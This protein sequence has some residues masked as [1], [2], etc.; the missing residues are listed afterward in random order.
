LNGFYQQSFLIN[1]SVI[2]PLYNCAKT[3][4]RCLH[5]LLILEY[6]KLEVILVD[7]GSTDNTIKIAE[8]F[9]RNYTGKKKI[10]ILR[11]THKGPAAA[12]NL[13][14]KYS[15]GEI[16]FF[17]DSDCEVPRN[18]IKDL[19]KHFK[20]RNIG[21]VGGGVNPSSLSTIYEAFEQ[22]RREILY[23]HKKKFLND[24]PTC[25]LAVRK[26]ILLEIGGFDENFKYASS[27][28]YELCHRIRK[29][30]YKIL[31]DPSIYVIHHHPHTLKQILRRAVTHGKEII[32]L[33]KK[34]GVSLYKEFLCLLGFPRSLIKTFRKYPL[35]LLPIS[36]FYEVMLYYGR[37]KGITY[38]KCRK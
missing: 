17:T 5:S 25:N 11:Q 4:R 6:P 21:A 8:K 9:I 7:D 24:L 27:E 34:E 33:E 35:K 26:D 22:K 12:R 19:L 28:D 38:F 1:A 36:F 10:T 2:I 16:I 37:V 20:D 23:G 29:L 13:G 30:G 32:K 14:I 18:W 15:E 3:L 31:Y